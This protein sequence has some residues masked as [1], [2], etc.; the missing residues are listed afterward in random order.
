MFTPL[1]TAGIQQTPYLLIQFIF[2]CKRWQE[3]KQSLHPTTN[4]FAQQ[5]QSHFHTAAPSARKRLS[6]CTTLETAVIQHTLELLIKI[7]VDFKK[8]QEQRQSLNPT[9]RK[10]AQNTQSHSHTAA[11]SARKWLSRCTSLETAGI[12]HTPDL[13]N[14]C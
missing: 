12:Q 7:I 4:M 11:P 3:Q 13:F 1:E 14:E 8:L 9:T 10:I 6:R 5:T 2:H